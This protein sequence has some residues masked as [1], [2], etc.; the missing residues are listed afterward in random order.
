MPRSTSLLRI[1]SQL[2]MKRIQQKRH[3]K[4]KHPLIL[5]PPFL[6][7]PTKMQMP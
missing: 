4:K 6:L 1:I 5:A 2:Y 7:I 3:L